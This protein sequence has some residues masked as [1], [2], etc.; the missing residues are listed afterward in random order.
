MQKPNLVVEGRRLPRI[1]SLAVIGMT[2]LKHCGCFPQ[3][4]AESM[5]C[6]M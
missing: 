3:M 2:T 4:H 1:F 5:E 6:R